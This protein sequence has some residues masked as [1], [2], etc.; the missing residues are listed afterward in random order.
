[1]F[2]H[3]KIEVA[4]VSGDENDLQA[5]TAI[6]DTERGAIIQVANAPSTEK[7]EVFGRD[8]DGLIVMGRD[9]L[10]GHVHMPYEVMYVDGRGRYAEATT[11]HPVYHRTFYEMIED[12]RH[13]AGERADEGRSQS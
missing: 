6:T 7:V 3:P 11:N 1:M 4:V 5:L 8:H 2:N 13:D 12:V 9:D 10:P